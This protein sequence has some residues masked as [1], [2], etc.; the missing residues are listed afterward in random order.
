[1]NLYLY[2]RIPAKDFISLNLNI[3]YEQVNIKIV[4]IS[5]QV[6]FDENYTATHDPHIKI[7]VNNFVDGIYVVQIKGQSLFETINFLKY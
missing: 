3:N 5:G 2:I 4:S 6:V 7:N 1:M